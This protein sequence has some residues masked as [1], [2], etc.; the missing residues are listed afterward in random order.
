[1]GN[2]HHELYVTHTLATHFLLGNLHTATVAD[3][4]LVTDALVLTAMA[5]IVL[6]WTED[7]LAEEAVAFGLVGAIVDGFGL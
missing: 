5:F 2:R 4:A 1:M 7:A 6:H 3:D